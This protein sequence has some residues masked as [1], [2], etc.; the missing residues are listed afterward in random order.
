MKPLTS[1]V[2]T[3]AISSVIENMINVYSSQ[4]KQFERKWYDNNFFDDG[5]HFRYLSRTTGKIVD[6]SDIA[7]KISP[8]RAIPKASRQIRGVVNLLL[9]LD[10]HPSIYPQNVSRTQFRG[11]VDPT[12]GQTFYPGY[13]EA[14]EQAKHEAQRI[15]HWV[16]NEWRELMLREQ[17]AQMVLLSAKHGVSFMQIYPDQDNKVCSEV[18]DAFDIYLAGHLNDIYKSPLITKAIPVP[19]AEIK[20]NPEFDEMAREKINPDNKYASSEVKQAYM[21]AKFGSVSQVEF[22]QTLLQK[23]TFIKEYWSEE[24]DE[25]VRK[26]GRE[27][28]AL[29][30]K[31]K[32]D[33]VMRHT[34]STSNG[35]LKDEYLPLEEYPFVDY[36]M[37]PG[38]IYQVPLIERL[39]PT[40][41]SLD[42]AVSRIEGF[43]N[44]MTVGVYQK[45]KGDNY[46]VSNMPGGQVI[47]YETVPLEQMQSASVPAYAFNFI[48]L[49]QQFIE[50]QGA[51]TAALGQLPEGVRSGR[52]IESIKATE[53]AN[54][55]MAT[56]RLKDTTTRI[57][58]RM[59]ELAATYYS[60]P[61]RVYQLDDEDNPDYFEVIGEAGVSA[62]QKANINPPEDVVVI[63]KDTKVRIDIESGLGYT[64]EGKKDTMIQVVQYL[65]QLA[66]QG[67]VGPEAIKVMLKRFLEI[68]QF[69]SIQEFMEAFDQDAGDQGMSEDETTK[70][71]IA[72]AEVLKD[73]GMVGPERDE[74]DIMKS[75]VAMAE[76][77][78]DLGAGIVP[79]G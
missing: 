51:S 75:K 54:L 63:K 57:T 58:E 6:Q 36:R 37:E 76:A 73:T 77:S 31:S 59:I 48:G 33:I 34:F 47:E 19:I 56:D 43:F 66:Q 52:A 16:E 71:K 25:R 38:M 21:Q 29:E 7:S 78:Q 35:V 1:Q 39:I 68:F 20:N 67:L 41:K 13:Q 15:G 61:Q 74:Q 23:E 60:Q 9:A 55:K 4:R 26:L 27:N 11:Q 44:T 28:G 22:Q 46:R 42:I 53:Y 49:L 14:I 65:I 3:E 40:N 2:P 72:L 70:M 10:P 17:L 5:Y 69:G 8:T 24:N 18:F 30:G 50:E 45:R 79:Q 64:M 12:T 32:G 62:M